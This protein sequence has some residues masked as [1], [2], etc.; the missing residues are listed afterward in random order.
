MKN[1][2]NSTP[3][4]LATSL[5][6]IAVLTAVGLVITS[7]VLQYALAIDKT[8][9]TALH[10][11]Y[12][13]LVLAIAYN[14][15]KHG[16]SLGIATAWLAV[17]GIGALLGLVLYLPTHAGTLWLFFVAAM[18]AT[19]AVFVPVMRFLDRRFASEDT[20]TQIVLRRA[21]FVGI[22]AVLLL[23]LQIRG[24]LNLFTLIFTVLGVA[25]VAFFL[26]LR[27]SA[28]WRNLLNR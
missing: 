23:W 20:A 5:I 24:T 16:D 11:I 19:T 18:L 1:W 25:M 9:F 12:G 26:E 6:L 28:R 2:F 27:E 13:V 8:T 17:V 14:C 7:F 10:A 22:L 3:R 15:L 21:G 4:L